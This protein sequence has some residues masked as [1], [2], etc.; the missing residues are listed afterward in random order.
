MADKC[1]WEKQLVDGGSEKYVKA[2]LVFHSCS[3]FDWNIIEYNLTGGGKSKKCYHCKAD[4]RKPEPPKDTWKCIA[5]CGGS[6]VLI[7]NSK[8]G[9][10][11]EALDG[12][13]CS[14]SVWEKSKELQKTV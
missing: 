3:K 10:E 5:P 1:V 7:S 14:G 2:G 9:W 6:C 12:V 13:L 4:I 8:D 11:K